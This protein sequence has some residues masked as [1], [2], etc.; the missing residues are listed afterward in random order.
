M[1]AARKLASI[2]GVAAGDPIYEL[3]KAEAESGYRRRWKRVEKND[4]PKAK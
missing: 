2:G 3:V 4:E 1:E